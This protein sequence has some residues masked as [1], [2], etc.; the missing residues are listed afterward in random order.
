L[1]VDVEGEGKFESGEGRPR[2][3][4]EE[5][6]WPLGERMDVMVK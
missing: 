2:R 5:K 3:D 4:F 6:E 1:V